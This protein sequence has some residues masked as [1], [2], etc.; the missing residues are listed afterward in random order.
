MELGDF[1]E[2]ILNYEK[3]AQRAVEFKNPAKKVQAFCQ[4]VKCY[5]LKGGEDKENEYKK[6]FD[7]ILDICK[8]DPMNKKVNNHR[9]GLM[10]FIE[11]QKERNKS[12]ET[13]KFIKLYN[14]E[15]FSDFSDY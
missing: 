15:E 9:K 2:A 11:E 8:A 10:D 12:K 7:E 1:K 6:Y 4:I 3:S 14:E 5:I 13:N